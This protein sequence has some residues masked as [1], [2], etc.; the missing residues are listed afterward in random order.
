MKTA[1]KVVETALIDSASGKTLKL[2]FEARSL[3]MTAEGVDLIKELVAVL[4]SKYDDW[5]FIL[6]GVKIEDK[7]ELYAAIC[8]L[9]TL[10]GYNVTM[11]LKQRRYEEQITF[12]IRSDR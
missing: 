5:T 4:H 11:K 7:K 1:M 6:C 12:V 8:A 2:R 10:D 9:Q 3:E